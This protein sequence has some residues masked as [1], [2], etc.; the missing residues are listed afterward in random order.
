VT[1]S[2]RS[3]WAVVFF[4]MKVLLFIIFIP[5]FLNYASLQRE[6]QALSPTGETSSSLQED[7][8][9]VQFGN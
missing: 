8:R 5:A 9:I 1:V 3:C 2:Q 4:W 6:G 7:L